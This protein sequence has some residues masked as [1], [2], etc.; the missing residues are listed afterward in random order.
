M[1]NIA[2]AIIVLLFLGT[3]LFILISS[4]TVQQHDVWENGIHTDGIITGFTFGNGMQ[5]TLD[6]DYRLQ[7]IDRKGKISDAYFADY[8]KNQPLKIII[9]TKSNR[10]D[11]ASTLR[12]WYL[13]IVAIGIIGG[14]LFIFLTHFLSASQLIN[15]KAWGFLLMSI[16]VGIGSFMFYQNK[17]I[18]AFLAASEVVTS[19]ISE[20]ATDTCTR[21]SGD[22][23]ISYT[24]Y[25]P[26]YAY[27]FGQA[28]YTK[29][30]EE[31]FEEP[32]SIGQLQKLYVWLENPR[33]A[34]KISKT[35]QIGYLL[36]ILFFGFIFSYGAW[37]FL[38][39][40]ERGNIWGEEDE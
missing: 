6:I 10:I 32:L 17:S 37:L 21:R 26:T 29:I 15:Q 39:F 22:D 18:R 3:I 25:R 19:T 34:K 11:W 1:Q 9:D 35:S 40:S 24:C 8:Q 7:G 36:G 28:T 33:V 23:D 16:G 12:F 20:I 14:V 4:R 31:T 5:G 13:D 38:S 30:S 27:S 2:G